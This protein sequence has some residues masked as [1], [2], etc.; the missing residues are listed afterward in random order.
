MG[1]DGI[2]IN[3]FL[4]ALSFFLPVHLY[5]Y[6]CITTE[7]QR[8]ARPI[9]KIFCMSNWS[10]CLDNFYIIKF[11]ITVFFPIHHFSICA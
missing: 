11:G 2:Y 3:K 1:R 8:T 7:I 5:F 4:L 9:G 6:M 10:G